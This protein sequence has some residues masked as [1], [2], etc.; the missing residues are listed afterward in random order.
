MIDSHDYYHYIFDNDDDDDPNVNELPEENVQCNEELDNFRPDLR[1]WAVRNNECH[2]SI[3]ELLQLLLKYTNYSLPKDARTLLRT[4]R[5]TIYTNIA[6]GQY[7][8]FGLVNVLYSLME[9]Y[10]KA[11][12]LVNNVALSL[13]IDGLPISRSSPH[14]LWP[15]LVADEIFKSVHIIGIYYGA[16]KPKSAND[17]LETFVQELK[18]F[19]Q[20]GFTIYITAVISVLFLLP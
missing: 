14:C 13:N 16:G 3:N 20:D 8:H 6:G 1:D 19:I 10:T 4:P 15:I 18:T 7:L 2:K 11:G 17:F 9:Q 5:T 12:L